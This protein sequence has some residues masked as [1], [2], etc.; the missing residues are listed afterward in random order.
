MRG[1]VS[2]EARARKR[3]Q[4]AAGA[5]GAIVLATVAIMVAVVG[6]NTGTGRP[7]ISPAA[8][9]PGSISRP[10]AASP[11]TLSARPFAPDSVWNKP[12]PNDAPLDPASAVLVKTLR[13]TVAQNLAAGT[14]PGISRVTTSTFYIVPRNQPTTHVQLDTGPWGASLERALREVPIP[15]RAVPALGND[16]QMTI[17]QP[18]TDRMWELFR[19]S[20]QADG[21]H[22]TWGGAMTRVSA[23]HGYYTRRS[24]PG[25]SLPSWGATASSLPVIAGTIMINELKA[26]VIPHALAMNIPWARPKVYSWPAQRT[27][28]KSTDPNAIPEGAHFRLDPRLDLNSLNLPPVTRMIAEAAQRYGIIV[29]DQTGQSTSFFAEN[30]GRSA[31]DPYLGP[32]GLF[33]GKTVLELMQ[34]FPWDHLELLKMR[35]HAAR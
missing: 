1:T 2:P 27:D 11:R 16:A 33:G 3:R 31:L 10:K 34:A 5:A 7:Q 28:G 24:W 19:A 35:L 8:G 20:R 22:A 18:S 32:N 17:W 9:Q 4:A 29:R 30:P 21:W 25:L 26:G 12:L 6:G 14:G 23:S 13:D 15:T